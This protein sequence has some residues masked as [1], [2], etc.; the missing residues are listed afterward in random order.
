[1]PGFEDGALIADRYRV[2]RMIGRGGMGMVYEVVDETTNQRLAIKTL[3]PQ[4]TKKKQALKRFVREVQVVRELNHP[5]VVKITDAGEIENVMYYT[6]EFLE[7]KSLRHWM[8][9]RKRF[10]LGSTVRVLGMLCSA[11]EHAHP[12]SIIHR[13]ISPENVMVTEKGTVKL[14]DFGLSKLDDDNSAALTRVGVSLGKI[15]YGAPEQLTDAKNVDHRADI[16]AL[17]VMFYEMLSGALPKPDIKLTTL[18]PS[19]PFECDDFAER[20][21]AKDPNIRPPT[22]K[23]F[24]EELMSLYEGVQAE[25]KAAKQVAEQAVAREMAAQAP[26]TQPPLDTT[27]K[28]EVVKPLGGFARFRAACGQF[29]SRITGRGK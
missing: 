1:M 28:G 14:L 15:Q 27:K 3:L 16:Y 13:D 19:I 5:C 22:A 7:G 21:I 18:V 12:K 23:A 26:P 2:G 8:V 17:G 24:R 11:L 10:G 4:Y 25:E 20:A 6:M 9:Q 29:F